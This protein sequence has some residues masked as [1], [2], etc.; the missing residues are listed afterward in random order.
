MQKNYKNV[1]AQILTSNNSA[2]PLNVTF[3][4]DTKLSSSCNLE[5]C[6]TLEKAVISR[7]P[8]QSKNGTPLMPCKPTK[9]RKLLRDGKATKHWSKLGVFYI[10]LNFNPESVLNQNQKMVLG[11]DSGSKFDG[12]AVTSK[13][14][15]ITG[16]SELPTGIADKLEIKRTMRRARRFRNCRRREARFDNRGKQGFIAPSQKSKVDFRLKIVKELLKLFSITDFAVEDVKFNHHKKRGGK[17]FSTVEI[18]KSIVYKEL[19]KLG[20]LTL[21][22]GFETSVKR[23]ELGLKKSSSKSKRVPEAHATDAITLASI[24]KPLDSLE[25]PLFLV[26]KRNQNSRRQLHR[27]EPDKKGIRTR[28]GGSNSL[29][30]FK[31]NDVIIY[32][33]ELARIGGYMKNKLSL[34]EFNIENKRFTQSGNPTDCI[35]LFNQKLIYEQPAQM[36]KNSSPSTSSGVSFLTI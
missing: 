30:G 35:K 17:H 24:V 14:V 28:Y 10:K 27:F 36:F 34:H 2:E 1:G 11:L 21:I 32:K 12:Y 25:I 6:S 7:I 31:K 15:N 23:K 5:G 18:G 16:M 33:G 29:A 22:D 13:T 19:K 20:K 4:S 3:S 8:V 26:W 9:A